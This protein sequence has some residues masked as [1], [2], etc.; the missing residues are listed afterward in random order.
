MPI[1]LDGCHC[2]LP[3]LVP[4]TL[5]LMDAIAHTRAA[6]AQ[7]GWATQAHADGT[8]IF[9]QEFELRRIGQRMDRI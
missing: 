8:P 5:P 2:P 4:L 3:T 9:R 1:L 7:M 6:N